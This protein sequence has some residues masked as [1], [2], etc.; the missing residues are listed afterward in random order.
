LFSKAE[1]Y[2]QPLGDGVSRGSGSLRETRVEIRLRERRVRIQRH[3]GRMESFVVACVVTMT[4]LCR[5]VRAHDLAPP[6]GGTST[7]QES[8]Q[9]LNP[10]SWRSNPWLGR[11]RPTTVAAD[12]PATAGAAPSAAADPAPTAEATPSKDGAANTYTGRPSKTVDLV[13]TAPTQ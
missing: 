3:S 1:P 9:R 7:A 12:P 10:W 13:C 8:S 2:R 11:S 5:E 6:A 4:L